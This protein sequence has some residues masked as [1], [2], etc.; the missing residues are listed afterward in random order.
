MKLNKNSKLFIAGHRGLVGSRILKKYQD[1][2][3]KNIVT[4][5]RAELDLTNQKAVE[6][7]FK[8][9]KPEY[10]ID[11]AAKVGGIVANKTHQADFLY[12]NLSM[13]NNLIW[14]SHIYDVKKL[15]FLG[16]SCIYPRES[17]QP[18]KE[19]YFMT[20]PLEPTNE[21]YAIAKIA[22]MK[23]C[24]RISE[25]YGKNFISVMPCNIYGPGDHFDPENSHVIAATIRKF[26]DAVEQ[27]LPSVEVWGT[28]KP[29]REFLYNEDLADAVY[30][31]MENYNE[32][33][34][35][36]VGVG[37]D[38]SIKNLAI[39]VKKL[40]DYKGEIVF[41]TEKPDGMMRKVMDVSRLNALGWKPKTS[42]EEGLEKTIEWY[43]KNR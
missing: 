12:E 36:N 29:K 20:G 42:F 15:M 28:G 25:Q 30:Y 39:L 43:K 24:E 32:R 34:F 1:E 4:R 5:T 14:F 11:A 10:V 33:E 31:L 7:F 27:D 22:G 26:V 19:E 37:D 18:I 8:K 38:I 13:Q 3:Y 23:L 40:T 21:G 6:K 35:I 16:S 41:N 9:E 2:G 17:K